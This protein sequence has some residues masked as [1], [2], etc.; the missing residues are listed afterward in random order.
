MTQ[1]LIET[2][3]RPSPT[4]PTIMTTRQK[5]IS[6]FVALAILVLLT[7]LLG[8]RTA[9]NEH[10][11]FSGYI[12]GPA[13]RMELANHL[14]DASNARAIAARN[15]VLLTDAAEVAAAKEA[16]AKAHAAVQDHLLALRASAAEASDPKVKEMVEAIAAIEAR[17]GPVAQDIVA[18]ASRGE[19][20]AAVAKMNAECNPLL[21]SLTKAGDAYLDDSGQRGK[22]EVASS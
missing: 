12:N 15:L 10:K 3:R 16:V 6:A 5:L 14:L 17:Y 1:W 13:K 18:K 4:S 8:L 11:S 9:S 2:I 21:A 7:A 20:D 22:E 19:R